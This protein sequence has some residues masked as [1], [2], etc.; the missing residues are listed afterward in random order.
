M[1]SERVLVLGGGVIGLSCA[2]EL[3][4]RGCEVAVLEAR[5]CGGQASGAAA[6]MLAPYSENVEGPDAFFQFCRQSLALYPQWKEQVQALSA[7]PFE[8]C[9]SGSLQIAYHEADLQVL[10][11]RAQWQ[12]AHGSTGAVVAGEALRALEPALAPQVLAALYTPEECHLYAPDY[13]AALEQACRNSGV[14]IHDMLGQV[15]IGEFDEQVS[16][17]TVIEGAKKKKYIAGD[18][19]LVCNGAWASGLA[20]RFGCPIPIYP[21]RGQICAYDAASL[22]TVKHMVFGPQGYLV[23]KANGTLV[24]G[25]SE[26]VAGYDSSVTERGIARLQRWNKRVIPELGQAEPFHR[27]AGLRPATQDGLPLIGRLP[28][29]K[30]VW[31]AAGHYRN[32]IL[33]SP[34]TAKLAADMLQGLPYDAEYADFAPQ[35]FMA[36]SRV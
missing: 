13:V 34:A 8:Y 31:L 30:R 12:Q 23:A 36:A 16:V 35:R 7:M 2:L 6:G 29:A 28:Q 4:L 25:A 15:E 19:L 27:W 18:R 24:C 3:R 32:G 26:D 11:G 5:R 9:H 33:L 17:E 20:E 10:A 21:I 22:P 14:R 1:G